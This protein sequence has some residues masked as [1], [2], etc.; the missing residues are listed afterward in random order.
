M[1]IDNDFFWS[2][3]CLTQLIQIRSSSSSLCRNPVMP[4]SFESGVKKLDYRNL[5][6]SWFCITSYGEK[7]TVFMKWNVATATLF[8][9]SW[10]HSVLLAQDQSIKSSVVL[11]CFYWK[12]F[13]VCNI[14]QQPWR[15]TAESWLPFIL[16][17]PCCFVFWKPVWPNLDL[18]QLTQ[19]LINLPAGVVVLFQCNITLLIII[20]R[21]DIIFSFVGCS[22]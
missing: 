16:V 2:C 22:E 3:Q 8:V 14:V 12:I 18:N 5:H 17:P 15:H 19:A 6:R 1:S 9:V 10:A 4:C 21:L 11:F 13:D 20:V 7:T